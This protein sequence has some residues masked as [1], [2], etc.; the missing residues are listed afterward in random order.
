M[1]YKI[2][3]TD[4]RK[5]GKYN[6]L[7]AIS[8]Q[9][10]AR[11]LSEMPR[12]IDE[13]KQLLSTQPE[14]YACLENYVQE[15]ENLKQHYD[16]KFWIDVIEKNILTPMEVLSEMQEKFHFAEIK[17]LREE[18]AF[19]TQ[20]NLKQGIMLQSFHSIIQP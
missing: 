5:I 1:N 11:L 18:L 7:Y 14:D 9:K 2:I 20:K 8:R 4:E 6:W 17:F 19:Y 10:T 16:K 12:I 3:D 13:A 15:L